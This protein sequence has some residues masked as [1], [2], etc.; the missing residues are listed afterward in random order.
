MTTKRITIRRGVRSFTL[1]YVGDK[2]LAQLLSSPSTSV[3]IG[4]PENAVFRL[5]GGHIDASTYVLQSGDELQIE[6]PPT[7]KN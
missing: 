4:A 7:E 2:T 5:N 1:E 6:V 3:R